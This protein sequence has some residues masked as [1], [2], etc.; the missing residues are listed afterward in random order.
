M[1]CSTCTPF[2][3]RDTTIPSTRLPSRPL[4]C[5]DLTLAAVVAA[6]AA[7]VPPP[8]AIPLLATPMEDWWPPSARLTT[9]ARPLAA[10][11]RDSGGK[12]PRPGHCEPHGG[13]G[14]TPFSRYGLASVV[15]SLAGGAYARRLILARCTPVQQA[16]P[17]PGRWHLQAA[18]P[19]LTPPRNGEHLVSGQS[20]DTTIEDR[21][22]LS[23]PPTNHTNASTC[24]GAHVCHR[25]MAEYSV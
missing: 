16:R 13:E 9:P 7:A 17:P 4:S 5:C 19:S 8:P 3:S 15:A 1:S 12:G 20:H 21:L 25:P 11:R 24:V 22:G 6:A 18:L 2:A 23:T 10:P 14:C